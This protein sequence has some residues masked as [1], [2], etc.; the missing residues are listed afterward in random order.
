MLITGKDKSD[1]LLAATEISQLALD[2]L[3]RDMRLKL[4]KKEKEVEDLKIINEGL[5][6]DKDYLDSERSIITEEKN[7]EI[8]SRDRTIVDY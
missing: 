1:A 8:R 3:N 2:F 6:G 7:Q 5:R 4:E